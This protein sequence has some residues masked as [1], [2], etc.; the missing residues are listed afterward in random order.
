MAAAEN[1]LT[2]IQP[3][4]RNEDSRAVAL[5][6]AA[7]EL[8]FGVVGHVGSGTSEIAEA[9]QDSLGDSTL[10]GGAFQVR[11]LNASDVIKH[12]ASEKG[13]G[14]PPPDGLAYSTTLQNWGDE[15]RREA[16]ANG[17]SDY[18]AVARLLILKIK[19]TRAVDTGMPQ[20]GTDPVPPDGK[21][22]A[23][24]LDSL[25]HPA[26]VDLLRHVYQDAFV[27]IGVGCEEMKRLERLQEKYEEAGKTPLSEFMKRDAE[28]H[29]K[30]GQKVADTFHLSDFLSITPQID[31]WSTMWK[32]L[33]GTRTKS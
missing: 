24:I 31:G 11:I 3:V 1:P 21:R 6:H 23:Y 29:E 4:S 33:I 8:V 10:P 9:L 25:R 17:A 32:T 5:Q 13:R 14:I 16:T 12:W 26:E 7:N 20:G 2:V 19:D 28:A 15:M 27:L 18:S 30:Y 22:R